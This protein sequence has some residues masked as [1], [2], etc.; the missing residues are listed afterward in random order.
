MEILTLPPEM[1]ECAIR[2]HSCLSIRTPKF[3]GDPILKWEVSSQSLAT[4]EVQ[5]AS[6]RAFPDGIRTHQGS[7]VTHSKG[8]PSLG[9][10]W[11]HAGR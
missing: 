3:Q 10:L 7:I 1:R 4:F 5:N 9:K 11:L 6:D 8:S 2:S